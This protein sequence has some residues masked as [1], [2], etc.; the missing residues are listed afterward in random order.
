M[1]ASRRSSLT[2]AF[3]PKRRDKERRT[4]TRPPS[5]SKYTNSAVY[6]ELN[7]RLWSRNDR[8]I[9]RT[10]ALSDLV[11]LN[12]FAFV[13]WRTFYKREWI[14]NVHCPGD[15][16]TH[17]N[18]NVNFRAYWVA[19]IISSHASI[20]VR[21]DFETRRAKLTARNRR[22]ITFASSHTSSVT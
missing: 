1:E 6:S 9:G 16:Y 22:K 11:A 10:R 2:R 3:V 12:V 19:T 4:R 18:G 15:M 20:D 21:F 13:S 8:K 7:R 17:W 14:I 5:A